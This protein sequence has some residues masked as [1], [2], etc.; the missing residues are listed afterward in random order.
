MCAVPFRAVPCRSVPFRA[1]P[2]RSVPFRAVTMLFS[3]GTDSA[4][5]FFPLYSSVYS[6]WSADD[7]L[8]AQCEMDT[9]KSTG[10]GGQHRNKRETAVRLKHL[11]SG[12]VAQGMQALLDLIFSV[13][14]SVSEAAKL[15]GLST[16]ALSRLIISD[17]SLRSA[18]NEIRT[19]KDIEE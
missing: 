15:L 17:D 14:G 19:L 7:E 18:V 16:G 8:M 4:V 13:E 2:C 1:V 11:P 6:L 5:L 3:D 10:P 9:Y 12:I